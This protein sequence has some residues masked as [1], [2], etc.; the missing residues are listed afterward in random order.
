[1]EAIKGILLERL[2]IKDL[3]KVSDLIYYDGP[4]LSHFQSGNN[5]NYLFFWAD[6]DDTFNRWLVVRVS[7]ERLQAYLNGKLTF[8]NIITEPNDNFVYKVDIDADLNYQNVLMLFPEQI[9]QSYLPD[10]NAKYTFDPLS[11]ELDLTNYS[12][13][14]NTGILQT[15][16]KNSSKVPYNEIDIDIFGPAMNSLHEITSGLGKAFIKQRIKTA[17]KDKNNKPQ[18][19]R[20]ALKHSTQINYFAQAGGSFSALFKPASAAVPMEGIPS[21]EDLFIQ[22][23]MNFISASENYEQLAEFVKSIDK[24]IITSYKGLLQ[25]IIGSKLK[26]YIRYENAI[27]KVSD[28]KD[29]NFGKANE[30]LNVLEKLEYDEKTDIKITGRFIALHVKTGHYE[31]EDIED[32]DNTS[33]GK[34]DKARLEMAFLIHF[35]KS[36]DVVIERRETKQ[37]G[38]KKPKIEDILV[39]F[40]ELKEDE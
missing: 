3:Q 17:P 38:N 9:P 30:I 2:P 23:V 20:A 39:S 37:A 18:I 8:Y 11:E 24:K 13:K 34:M 16:F 5:E 1:M 40:V 25:T 22:Y 7:I 6:V 12:L 10:R 21:D 15:Y 19:D 36:Y 32:K 28:R 29:L 26:F 31:F 14:Y 35:D 27:T 4:L 33:K